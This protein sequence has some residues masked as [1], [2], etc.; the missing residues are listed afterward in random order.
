MDGRGRVA[1]PLKRPGSSPARSPPA[2][3]SSE[4]RLSPALAKTASRISSFM[5]F[6]TFRLE[7]L[8]IP[9]F[10]GM[11]ALALFLAA[12]SGYGAVRG[13]PLPMIMET[14]SDW[15]GGARP[16]HGLLVHR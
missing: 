6:W 10:T 12:S 8:A 14:L 5:R 1:G 13:G 2:P 7:G 9:R 4:L 11:T 15:R 16:F 3:A